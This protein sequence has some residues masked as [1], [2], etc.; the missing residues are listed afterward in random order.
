MATKEVNKRIIEVDGFKIII[1]Q[2]MKICSNFLDIRRSANFKKTG[3]HTLD[4][5]PIC[6]EEIILNDTIQIMYNNF[7]LFPNIMVHKKCVDAQSD[8]QLKETIRDLEK[9]Y[10]T[11]KELMK[12]WL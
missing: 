7:K 4:I 8:K 9:S 12:I 6:M 1:A 10:S 5:C 2:K 3:K 11:F